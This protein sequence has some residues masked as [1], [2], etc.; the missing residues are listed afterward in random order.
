[1]LLLGAGRPHDPT[2]SYS[3]AQ[4]ECGGGKAVF[5]LAK[6]ALREGMN[7]IS[8]RQTLIKL[9]DWYKAGWAVVDEYVND[10]LAHNSETKS[11]WSGCRGWPSVSWL[12]GENPPRKPGGQTQVSFRELET[13]QSSTT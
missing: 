3:V 1:M 7:L 5:D 10:D 2:A 9:A 6:E 12:R 11:A 4:A 13:R 8:C